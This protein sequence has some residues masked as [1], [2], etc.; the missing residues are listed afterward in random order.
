MSNDLAATGTP[1]LEHS[2]PAE[3]PTPYRRTTP[4]T[5]GAV[6]EH[7]VTEKQPPVSDTSSMDKK[8]PLAGEE[9]HKARRDVEAAHDA[10]MVDEAKEHRHTL[11]AKWRPFI[12][13]AVALV[14]LGWWISSLTLKATRH[15]WIVQSIFAWAFILSVICSFHLFN[16][17]ALTFDAVLSPSGSYQTLLSPSLLVLSGTRLCLSRSLLCLSMFASEW[18]GWPSL[19]SYLGLHSASPSQRFVRFGFRQ[20]GQLSLLGFAI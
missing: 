15:R 12:L 16:E 10:E 5:D 18:A 2:A 7:D 6:H 13:G 4:T 1:T 11:Y 8:D 3:T 20:L 14:I 9:G 17:P 19:R